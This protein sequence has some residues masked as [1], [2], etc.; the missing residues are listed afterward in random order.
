MKSKRKIEKKHSFLANRELK[1]GKTWKSS[2]LNT[3]IDLAYKN[4]KNYTTKYRE[5]KQFNK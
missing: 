1:N 4:N 3:I 5:K 2:D